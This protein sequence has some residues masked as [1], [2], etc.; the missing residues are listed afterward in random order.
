MSELKNLFSDHD[1]QKPLDLQRSST[2][3]FENNDQYTQV[4]LQEQ[5]RISSQIFQLLAT[6]PVDFEL[7]K[8]ELDYQL[9]KVISE[10]ELLSTIN[11]LA[12]GDK[13]YLFSGAVYTITS[14][15][16]DQITC[17]VNVMRQADNS[18]VRSE[19]LSKS[20]LIQE[21]IVEKYRSIH[22]IVPAYKDLSN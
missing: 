7:I 6:K 22:K 16:G 1:R 13:L 17:D 9:R 4:L 18:P 8:K 5:I 20:S 2:I 12:V 14:I 21:N 3:P 15:E 11:N 10:Y 19:V